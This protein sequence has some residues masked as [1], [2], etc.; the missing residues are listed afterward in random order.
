MLYTWGP[1]VHTKCIMDWETHEQFLTNILTLPYANQISQTPRWHRIHSSPNPPLQSTWECAYILPRAKD[2]T[3]FSSNEKLKFEEGE[4]MIRENRQLV[5]Y[6]LVE[7][8]K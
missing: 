7:F 1:E 6:K 5:T 8:E 4:P 3:R 2:S